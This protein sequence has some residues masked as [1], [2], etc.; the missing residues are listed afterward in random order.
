MLEAIA[1]ASLVTLAIAL[2]ILYVRVLRTEDRLVASETE[3]QKVTEHAYG[4]ITAR[5][6]LTEQHEKLKASMAT[7][8]GEYDTLKR[9][10]DK[11]YVELDQTKKLVPKQKPRTT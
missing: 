2:I 9:T 7:L 8:Q 10:Y 5:L 11:L 6:L 4:E 1:V 3:R